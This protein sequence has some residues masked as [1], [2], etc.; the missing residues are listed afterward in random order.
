MRCPKCKQQIPEKSLKCPFCHARA[1]VLCKKCN[2]YNSVTSLNCAKCSEVLLKVCP[3]CKGVNLPQASICRKCGFNFAAPKEPPPQE[4][5][6]ERL[7]PESLFSQPASKSIKEEIQEQQPEQETV[8]ISQEQPVNQGASELS[9]SENVEEES[10][11]ITFTPPELYSQQSAKEILIKGLTSTDKKII[12]LSGQKGIGK[13]VVLKSTI[14]E[15]RDYGITWLVGECS[16]IT[17]LSPCGLIQDILLTFFNITNVCS[18]SL[19]LKKESQKFFQSE[20]PT[21]TNEEIFN[22]LNLLYPTNTAYYENILQNKEKTFTFLKK[23]FE[24]IL[25][26]NRGIFII[27]N[28]D[29]IDGLSYE[30]LYKIL[31][32]KAFGQTFKILLTY[33]ET[34][35]ARGYLYGDDMTTNEYLDVSLKTFDKTQMG[36]FID[37]YFPD[38]PCPEMAKGIMFSL[39]AGNPA[40]LE[41]VVNLL[42]DFKAKNNSLDL[43]FPSSFDGIVNMRLNFL[44][45]SSAAYEILSVAAIQGIKF[46]PAIIN[47]IL[48]INEDE[49]LGILDFL[50]RANFIVQVNEFCYAFKSSMLWNSV[51]DEIKKDR[52]FVYFNENLYT[53]YSNYTLSSNSL[54]AVITQNLNQDVNAFKL[55][56]DNIKIASYIGD[57]N[58]YI[59][60]Q[61]QCLILI[62][63]IQCENSELVRRNIY[64]R[65]GKLLTAL[66]PQEA[67]QY[68]PTAITNAR[69]LLDTFKEIE[70]TGYLASCCMKLDDYYGVLECVDSVVAKLSPDFDLELAMLKSRK[71]DALLKIGNSGEIIN[72]VD[73]EIMPVFDRY[74]GAKPHKNIPVVSLYKT[75]LQTYLILAN[76]LVFQGNSRSFEVLSTMFEIFEKNNFDDK[77]FVCKTKLTLAFANTIKGEA[78]ASEEILEDII[79]TYKTDVMDN[80]SISRWNLINILNNFVQH[81]YSGIQEELFQVVTFANNINDNFTKNILK[82]LLGKLFKDESLAKQALDIY[83]EQITYFSKEKNALGAL[84]TWYLMADAS[85][86]VEGPDKAIDIAQKALDVAQSTKINNYLFIVLYNKVLAEAYIIQAE[87]E[88]AKAHIEKAVLVAKKFE[89]ME[90]VTELYLIYG[91]YLQDIALVKTDGRADYVNGANKMYKK[92]A[93][94]AQEI[95]NNYLAAKI[96]TA[97]NALYSFCQLNK[98]SLNED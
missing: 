38:E 97:Q 66:N 37:Q 67:I 14:H 43:N 59:I 39:S 33:N 50:Q 9:E 28:F 75:W 44:R 68:L 81:K 18:D 72:I 57:T 89:L 80:E 15:L 56:T 62:D 85:L 16:P 40:V 26:K 64:E 73:N 63:K 82:T 24:T 49:F 5:P 25:E 65:L 17:Q 53:A 31:N 58:L 61:K 8:S 36:A 13:S 92:A 51:L 96:K 1:A 35:P 34:R 52:N 87:Y 77:L 4:A 90:L 55:W 3:S 41:Q 88:L 23:V 6:Q 10:Q 20:F 46:N 93:L 78:I 98:I 7:T 83:S 86:V 94:I 76:A 45:E 71:L 47:Q 91:K 69:N 27:E 29:F 12:S 95:K 48:D 30:F 32:D 70:L 22:L 74:I 84:L 11:G 54:M 21:L 19:R 79:K 2:T 60:S 42:L